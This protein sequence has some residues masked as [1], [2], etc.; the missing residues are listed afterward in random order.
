MALNYVCI[1]FQPLIKTLNNTS[2]FVPLAPPALV[3]MPQSVRL[4]FNMEGAY[5]NKS[6][7]L[8]PGEMW[9]E[10]LG[11]EGIY[12]VSNYGRFKRLHKTKNTPNKI[13]CQGIRMG[14]L[15]VALFKA[16]SR[17]TYT[18]HR[19]VL[20]VFGDNPE[21][22][23]EVN[24]INGLKT[25]NR[26]ENLEWCTPVEN[27]RHAFKTGLNKGI[28]GLNFGKIGRLNAKSK[29]TNQYYLNGEFIREW[30]SVE[31]AAKSFNKRPAH[32]CMVARTGRG[33]CFGF[34]WRY[35]NESDWK[36]K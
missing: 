13:L 17:K 23:P 27:V 12:E 15:R 31:L 34:K 9:K 33:T 29:P 7:D 28:P 35:K 3:G 25:D 14:Y 11:Y 16:N 6:L 1:A 30:E 20:Q 36:D 4:F 8:L 19:V 22:K 26:V 2:S 10:I 24:H 21:N 18:S 32:L 5:K